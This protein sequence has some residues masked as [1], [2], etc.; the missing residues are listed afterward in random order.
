MGREDEE[1]CKE[2]FDKF[3]KRIDASKNI[4]WKKVDDPPD[5]ELYLSGKKFAVEATSI[6]D[7]IQVAQ[8]KFP[9][10][11]VAISFIRLVDDIKMTA[12]REGFLKGLYIIT[13]TPVKNL[14]RRKTKFK[15]DCLEYIRTTQH[16]SRRDEKIIFQNRSQSYSI[17]KIKNSPNNVDY[18]SCL[19]VKWG[20]EIEKELSELIQ[21]IL[22]VKKNKLRNVTSPKI[23]L[24]YNRHVSGTYELYKKCA[25][26][27][28]PQSGF[29][30]IFIVNSCGEGY[31]VDS[32]NMSWKNN[33]NL[34]IS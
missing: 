9:L 34:L 10:I 30:A 6:F 17:C 19:Y 23:L 16:L 22:E 4:V 8:N 11:N 15:Q 31:I 18:M 5:Y 7:T 2:V 28:T 32:A 13:Y 1:C 20:T 33:W 14:S 21:E 24:I 3:L 29:H 25:T 27:F 26:F 12:A